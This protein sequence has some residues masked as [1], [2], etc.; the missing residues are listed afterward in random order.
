[1]YLVLL[2]NERAAA[3]EYQDFNTDVSKA[4]IDEI[5]SAQDFEARVVDQA[6]AKPD[7]TTRILKI[8]YAGLLGLVIGVGIALAVEYLDNSVREPEEV[9]QLLGAPVIA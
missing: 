9:E 5:N 8:V 2:L 4:R 3:Q 6:I 7:T 1:Q